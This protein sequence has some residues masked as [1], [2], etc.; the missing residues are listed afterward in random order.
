[1]LIVMMGCMTSWSPRKR[2]PRRR[3]LLGKIH[4]WLVTSPLHHQK[5]WFDQ[6]QFRFNQQQWDYHG[7][8]GGFLCFF[9]LMGISLDQR[10]AAVSNAEQWFPR[11]GSRGQKKGTLW[12]IF[13]SPIHDWPCLTLSFPLIRWDSNDWRGINPHAHGHVS[14]PEGK[15]IY[16]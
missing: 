6:Q 11:L 1:M 8:D 7:H 13:P 9:F 4:R 16:R 14:L 5:W 12:S 2:S 3:R 15:S 10:L